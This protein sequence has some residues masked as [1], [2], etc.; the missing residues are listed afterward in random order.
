MSTTAEMTKT[1][2]SKITLLPRKETLENYFSKWNAS[3][4]ENEDYIRS[5]Y[6]ETVKGD[7]E[8]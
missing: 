6:N 4:A 8:R 1:C 2:Y 5:I 7:Y 3:E